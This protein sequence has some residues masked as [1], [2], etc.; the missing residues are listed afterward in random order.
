MLSF[1]LLLCCALLVAGY[2]L[3]TV[4][5]W[6]MRWLSRPF[7]AYFKRVL[8]PLSTTEREAM[9]A[10]T[11]WWD[12]DLFS[13]KPDWS[14]LHRFP[15]PALSDEEQRFLDEVVDPLLARLNDFDIINRQRDL[16]ADVWDYLKQQGFFALIIPRHYGGKGFSNFANSTIVSRIA[17]RSLSA[18]VTVMVPN[19]L[20]PGELLLHYGTEEQKN[21]WLPRLASGQEF[22]CFALTGP[23]A[24][25]DAGAIPDVGIICRGEWSGEEILGIRLNWNK[26]YIT[27]AP[28]ATV[29]GLAFKLQ[30]PDHLL[31]ERSDY[32]ITCALIPTDHPGVEIGQRH[33]PMAQVFLNGPTRGHEVFIPLEWIIGGQ[34]YAGKGWR[35]L[36][37]CLSAGRGISL[38]ALGAACGHASTRATSAYAYVRRQFGL[39]IGRFEG[40]QEALARIGALTYQLEAT[41]RLTTTGLDMGERPGIVTAISKYHMTEM[42]R[43][44]L[45]DAMD[46]HGG[47]GVQLGPHN[48]LGYHWMGIPIAITVEGANILTRNLMIFGQGATR[49]HPYVYQEMAAAADADAEQGLQRFDA[50]LV[51]HIV[52]A[53]RNLTLGLASGLTLG[54]LERAPV[55]GATAC[56]YRQL[57]RLSRALALCTD[58]A[59]LTLGGELKRRELLSAR[60]GDVLSHLYL[61]SATLKYYE[62]Q[63]RKAEDLPYLHY[64]MRRSLWLVGQALQGVF[65]NLKPAW[66]GKLLKRALFPFGIRY[67]PVR[68]STVNALCQHLMQ[69][70]ALRDRL[71]ALCFWQPDESDPIGRVEL[72]FSAMLQIQPLERRVQE[73]QKQGVL[74]SKLPLPALLAAAQAAGLLSEQEIAMWQHA[75]RLRYQ[76]LQVDEFAP[77]ELEQMGPQAPAGD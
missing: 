59:M 72:A 75:D 14:K 49:C 18:A 23:E 69:P 5:P 34:E 73:A 67:R 33:Y 43:Q 24:G 7:F 29:L 41:R 68:D 37:E 55:A 2:L 71:S 22:P 8:P 35:M 54:K 70:S 9:E 10:G 25:S 52:F 40:V 50:L 48:Y 61:C 11:V 38:P 64:A 62:D 47:R 31:G 74:A 21:Y 16:P 39:P 30:D 19:S 51:R 15:A 63:G 1:M 3:L 13:G 58:V 12:G 42:A 45:C 57:T 65:D 53:L 60:L 4:A 28:R 32:G 77:G 20:G 66:V 17:T 44:I 6:R 46:I 36:V 27:L 56:Y 76:A 26:R